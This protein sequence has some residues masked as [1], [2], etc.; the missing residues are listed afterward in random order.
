MKDL[1]ESNDKMDLKL[2]NSE[3]LTENEQAVKKYSSLKK[4]VFY[5]LDF[6]WLDF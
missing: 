4:N 1:N 6:F 3:K 2:A 5:F